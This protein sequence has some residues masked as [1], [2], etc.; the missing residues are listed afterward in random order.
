MWCIRTRARV[1]I[2]WK[3]MQFSVKTIFYLNGNR[4][5]FARGSYLAQQNQLSLEVTLNFFNL[6]FTIYH[7]VECNRFSSW[8]LLENV[9]DGTPHTHTQ[10][11]R[12][13]QHIVRQPLPSYPKRLH[14]TKTYSSETKN[15]LGI[16]KFSVFTA[17][18]T[19]A[20]RWIC[21]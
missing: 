8:M 13:I 9:I 12:C 5:R 18:L 10:K 20:F 3:T 11:Q 2:H 15:K 17:L 19:Y 14:G 16:E 1:H 4:F 7:F 21:I 6:I